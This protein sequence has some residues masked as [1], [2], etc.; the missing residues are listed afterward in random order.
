[1]QLFFREIFQVAS[2]PSHIHRLIQG[3]KPQAPA[4]HRLPGDLL[5]RPAVGRELG[6]YSSARAA[7]ERRSTRSVLKSTTV[8]PSRVSKQQS[9]TPWRS[10]CSSAPAW[11]SWSGF[12][13]SR[14]W[15]LSPCWTW[16]W[17]TRTP[18]PPPERRGKGGPG[19]HCGGAPAPPVQLHRL[20][21][22]GADGGG[23]PPLRPQSPGAGAPRSGAPPRHQEHHGR[24]ALAAESGMEP[25]CS[26]TPRPAER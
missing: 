19:G 25:P 4:D 15:E 16:M 7:T 5:Q 12:P 9:T 26:S 6:R 18:S 22:P 20:Q 8:M 1:M 3:E 11:G 14:C 10:T 21:P 17:T 24:S 23:H 2:G 13:A